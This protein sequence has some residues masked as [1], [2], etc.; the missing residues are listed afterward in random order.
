M[1]DGK[2][3]ICC[4][5]KGLTI[6]NAIHFEKFRYGGGRVDYRNEYQRW[7]ECTD[8]AT[9]EEIKH[10]SSREIEERFYR[11]LEFGTGGLRGIIG[12]GTNRMN[13]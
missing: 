4:G 13:I 8:D 2:E 5:E 6:S 9:A 3:L 11:D 12:A 1:L 10:L 7:L